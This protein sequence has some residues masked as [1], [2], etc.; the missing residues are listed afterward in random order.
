MYE[1]LQSSF[2]SVL[3]W[4]ITYVQIFCGCALVYYGYR[5]IFGAPA[6]GYVDDF[7]LPEAAAIR[8]EPMSLADVEQVDN[9]DCAL[10]RCTVGRRKLRRFAAGRKYHGFVAK[11]D[12][13]VVG[14]VL[15]VLGWTSFHIQVL[16]VHPNANRRGIGT[17]LMREAISLAVAQR[18]RLATLLVARDNDPAI[19]LYRSLGFV[20]FYPEPEGHMLRLR[21]PRA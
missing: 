13:R 11:V 5:L 16:A 2:L 1:W 18:Y 7:V 17:T 8:I 9:I 4:A 14:F 12:D 6:S 20:L 3:Q 15:C 10:F 19:R 21:L